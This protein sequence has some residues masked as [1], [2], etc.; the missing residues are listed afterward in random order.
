MLTDSERSDS[1]QISHI[2]AHP[3]SHFL[4]GLP[5]PGACVLFFPVQTTQRAAEVSRSRPPAVSH[6]KNACPPGTPR[7][8]RKARNHLS[9]VLKSGTLHHSLDVPWRIIWKERQEPS[10]NPRRSNCRLEPDV[11]ICLGEA[12]SLVKT[13]TEV[14]SGKSRIHGQ[15]HHGR[16]YRMIWSSSLSANP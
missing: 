4:C 11:S 13:E 10:W 1:G 6:L 16:A 7:D 15:H 12:G 5:T 14:T 2:N 3:T 8:C 9:E